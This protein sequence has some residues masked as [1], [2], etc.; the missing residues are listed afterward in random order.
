MASEKVRDRV[1]ADQD[2]GTKLGVKNT[3]TIFV[4][5]KPMLPGSLNPIDLRAAVD[6][7]MKQPKP[8]ALK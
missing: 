7:A 6:E 2:E 4:N 5:Y 3:P 8:P 1:K